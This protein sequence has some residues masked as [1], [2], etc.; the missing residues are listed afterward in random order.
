MAEVAIPK[1]A[2]SGLLA[3]SATVRLAVAPVASLLRCVRR[4]DP[5]RHSL[6]RL[7]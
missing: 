6:P 5:Y 3:G 4:L 2:L 1:P 7:G